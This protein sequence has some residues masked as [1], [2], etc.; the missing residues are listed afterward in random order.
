MSRVDV[1]VLVLDKSIA[2]GIQQEALTRGTP[3]RPPARASQPS[4]ERAGLQVAPNP[5]TV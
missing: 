5:N 1:E 3:H 2:Q 4:L